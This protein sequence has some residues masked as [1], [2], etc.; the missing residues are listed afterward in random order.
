MTVNRDVKILW[1]NYEGYIF[2]HSIY[3]RILF[4]KKEMTASISNHLLFPD[5]SAVPYLLYCQI[6]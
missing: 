5:K 2:I 1:L 3:L 6:T 4:Y